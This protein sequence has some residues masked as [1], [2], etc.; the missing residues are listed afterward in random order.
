LLISELVLRGV[1]KTGKGHT[2]MLEGPDRKSYFVTAGVRF[3]DGFLIEVQDDALLVRQ[4]VVDPLSPVRSR[5]V[6]VELHGARP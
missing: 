5:E 1:V 6:R 2:A 4:E 3:Y